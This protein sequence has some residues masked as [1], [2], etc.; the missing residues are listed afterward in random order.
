M[1]EEEILAWARIREEERIAKATAE[2]ANASVDSAS[3]AP[4]VPEAVGLPTLENCP[5]APRAVASVGSGKS[6][7]G[8][9]GAVVKVMPLGLMLGLAL[10]A[11][12]SREQP[13]LPRIPPCRN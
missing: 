6:G 12:C 10:A 13:M 9:K 4:P 2:A 7:M 11:V 8:T 3:P 1:T 5:D